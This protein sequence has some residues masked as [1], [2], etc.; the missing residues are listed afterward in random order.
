NKLLEAKVPL[1]E[2]IPEEPE[3]NPQSAIY[4]DSVRRIRNSSFIPKSEIRNPQFF[5][6]NL[7][8]LSLAAR[9]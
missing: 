2:Q 6:S 8:F 7:N 1:W 4:S 9:G 3:R 5:S